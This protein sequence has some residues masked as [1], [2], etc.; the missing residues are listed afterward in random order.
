METITREQSEQIQQDIMT[1][2]DSFPEELIDKLCQI[3]VDFPQ[4]AKM[5][6]L[7]DK[8][9]EKIQP[10]PPRAFQLMTICQFI[11]ARVPMVLG[12]AVQSDITNRLLNCTRQLDGK[13]ED[14]INSPEWQSIMKTLGFD[15]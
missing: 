10:A 3:V 13:T 6:E 11:L 2:L 7:T 4:E 15:R 12:Y 1:H 8:E 14:I 9:I 5:E